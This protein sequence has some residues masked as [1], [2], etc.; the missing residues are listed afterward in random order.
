MNGTPMNSFER[1]RIA[2]RAGRI[3]I[4]C[5]LLL[6]IFKILLGIFGNSISIMADAF[7]NLSD[8]GSSVISLIGS[9]MAGKAAD[10]DHPF[11]HGRIEYIAAF[12]VAFLIVEVGLKSLESSVQKFFSGESLN[13]SWIGV[14][15]LLISIIVK[16][17]MGLYYRRVANQIDSTVFRT[18]SA[19]SF[20]D[21]LIT[22]ATVVS[23]LLY[24]IFHWNVDAI[25]GFLVSL[26]VIRNGVSIIK[27]TLEPLIGQSI[28]PK[29]YH[30][31]RGIV[32]EHQGIYGSHDLVLHNYGPNQYMGTIHVEVDGKQSIEDIHAIAD[33]IERQIKEE[34]GVTMVIHP[35]PVDNG[36]DAC[37]YRALAEKHLKDL[38]SEAS[39]HDFRL[40]RDRDGSLHI[41]FDI[42]LPWGI[43][44]EDEGRILEKMHL[45]LLDENPH[46]HCSI[47]LDHPYMHDDILEKG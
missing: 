30:S 39:I 47:T 8:A 21:M 33:H 18:S 42:L 37:Y 19:D 10:E 27:E 23:L 14:L 7:N 41:L 4:L 46:M 16:F 25:I 43:K 26:L 28:D 36:D 22:S 44:E 13:F 5:N 38:C 34:T 20:Q 6:F 40:H 3:G 11:G 45:R 35:D 15:V 29:L 2:I 24:G 32:E 17:G 12:V 31:I 9:K 1:T